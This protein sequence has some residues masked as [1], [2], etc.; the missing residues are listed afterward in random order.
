MVGGRDRRRRADRHRAARRLGLPRPRRGPLRRRRGRASVVDAEPARQRVGARDRHPARTVGAGSA[1]RPRRDVRDAAR[2]RGDGRLRRR[3]HPR[4]RHRA[5][6]RRAA[7]R[8]RRSRNDVGVRGRAEAGRGR[9][10]QGTAARRR[11]AAW[12]EPRRHHRDRP[13]RQPRRRHRGQAAG[14]QAPQ[15]RRPAGADRGRPGGARPARHRPVRRDD[16]THRRRRAARVPGARVR[17]GASAAADPTSCSCR[18]TRWISC[19]A[20]SAAS[21]ADA[22]QARR[23]RLDQHQDQGAPG[24]SRD[25]RRTGGAVRQ[26]A[27]RAGLR[28]RAGHPV[29]GRDGGRVRVHRDH[30]PADRHHRGQ[31]R[32]GEAGADGPGHLR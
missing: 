16:R 29:A 1:A 22:E 18:W 4:R 28:V 10:A 8:I 30:R 9:R 23:Q 24:G 5:P 27:G 21:R 25:R 32:H 2:P 13:D 31:V 6:R 11:G 19:P 12:R 3:R 26:A 14:R 20:T 7:R 17:V 15:R